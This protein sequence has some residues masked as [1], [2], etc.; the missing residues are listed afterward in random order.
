MYGKTYS[1][2]SGGYKIYVI[3]E[4]KGSRGMF[5]LSRDDKGFNE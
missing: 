1:G 4:G 2:I 5:P 3:K